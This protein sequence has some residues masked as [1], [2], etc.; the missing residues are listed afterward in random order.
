M[1]TV[2]T[3]LALDATALDF[4]AI[5]AGVGADAVVLFAFLAGV[6]AQADV[7]VAF[8]AAFAGEP[9]A[10]TTRALARELPASRTRALAGVLLAELAETLADFL[11]AVGAGF[12]AEGGNHPPVRVVAVGSDAS[13]DSEPVASHGRERDFP[14]TQ[15]VL[16][17][18]NRLFFD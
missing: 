17:F 3:A 8:L 2:G 16:D 1:C 4:A 15:D 11:P 9:V 14:L 13:A 12:A 10:F 18:V 5:L 7:A 6:N